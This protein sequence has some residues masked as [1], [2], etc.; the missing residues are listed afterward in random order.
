MKKKPKHKTFIDGFD[1]YADEYRKW[2]KTD[3]VPSLLGIYELSDDDFYAETVEAQL[4]AVGRGGLEV[5]YYETGAEQVGSRDRDSVGS[6]C[7]SAVRDP[8]G[9]VRPIIFI[10]QSVEL[11][12]TDPTDPPDSPEL[13]KV[14]ADGIR[15]L[16][17]IHEVGHAHDI[18]RGINFKH[19]DHLLNHVGAEAFA[20][21]FVIEHTRKRNYRLALGSYLEH[22]ETAA[23]VED[24]VVRTAAEHAIHGHDWAELKKWAAVPKSGDAAFKRMVEKAGRMSEVI[25]RNRRDRLK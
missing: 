18:A 1:S 14:V 5:V 24:T 21:S 7:T 13:E 15:L 12:P 10:R 16:A 25:E 22:L 23:K 19:D 9:K 4:D 3:L 20:H 17:L 2:K 6:G 11:T 8:Y